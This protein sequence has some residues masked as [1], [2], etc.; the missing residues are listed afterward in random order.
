MKIGIQLYSLRSM[1]NSQLD[2]TFKKL[3][4]F[5][6]EG[7]ELAG[8]YQ[9][10]AQELKNKLNEAQLEV[11]STH[12]SMNRLTSDINQVIEDYR[13]LDTKHI[14]IPYTDIKD[15]ETYENMLPQIKDVVNQLRKAGFM[16]HYHNHS[17]EFQR[18]DDMYVIEH[19]LKDVPEIRLE[20]DIYWATIAKVDVISFLEKYQDRID[21][22]HAKDMKLT[23]QGPYFESVGKGIIN[24]SEIY[25]I[26]NTCWIVEND[27]PANDPL[28]NVY[29][30][31]QYIHQLIGGKK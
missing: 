1:I 14:V 3:K 18:F 20:F 2:E 29:D 4:S 9:L 17:N 27:K 12:E 7:V 31:I 11:I 30:S 25:T 15:K 5:G 13:I 6:F 22:I 19:L 28:E 8:F 23:D 16:V 26:K 24:Y 21:I 10:T